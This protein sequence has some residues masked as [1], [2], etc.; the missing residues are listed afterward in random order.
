MIG[1]NGEIAFLR[2]TTEAASLDESDIRKQ[3]RAS[4]AGL[5]GLML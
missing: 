2:H 3:D 5:I 4:C 1:S